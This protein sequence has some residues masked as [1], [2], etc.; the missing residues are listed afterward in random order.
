MHALWVV[1]FL[2]SCG[3]STA[4]NLIGY[5]SNFTEVPNTRARCDDRDNCL[6]IY[7]MIFRAYPETDYVCFYFRHGD[8]WMYYIRSDGNY[9]SFGVSYG[10]ELGTD[11]K[12]LA[13]TLYYSDSFTLSVIMQ[14]MYYDEY[15]IAKTFCLTN[16]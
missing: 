9:K 14:C 11:F 4:M 3:S 6:N 8:C 2:F 13:Q 5:R 7:N 12:I 10:M 15:S 1:I 16:V